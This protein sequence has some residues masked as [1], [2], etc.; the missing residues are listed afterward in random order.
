[1]DYFGGGRVNSAKNFYPEKPEEYYDFAPAEPAEPAFYPQ[2][3]SWYDVANNEWLESTLELKRQKEFED[4]K[5]TNQG[6]K[7]T[8]KSEVQVR[9]G[10]QEEAKRLNKGGASKKFRF[11]QRGQNDHS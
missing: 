1:M 10:T 7:P 6:K 8:Q 3:R 9:L 4:D 2:L 5:A 11:F